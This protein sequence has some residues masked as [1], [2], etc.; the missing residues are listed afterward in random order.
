MSTEDER[1]TVYEAARELRCTS[2]WIR[3]LLAE[4]RLEGAQKV[5]GQWQIPAA[6]L[7]PLKQ[8]REAL[9]Q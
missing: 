6:A 5:D 7:E 3:T 8:R 4:Q 9:A 1:L 2:Q